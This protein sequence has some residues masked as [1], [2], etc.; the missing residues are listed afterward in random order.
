MLKPTDM[1]SLNSNKFDDASFQILFK[2]CFVPFCAYY[3]YKFGFSLD[4]AKEVVHTGF[5]KLWEN[6]ES[7]SPGLSAKAYLR[8]TIANTSLDL[9]KHEKVKQKHANYVFQTNTEDGIEADFDKI[10]IKQLS[11]D[12]SKAV[13]DLPD[14]MRLIFELSRNEGLKYAEIANRLDIS[15]KTVETQMSRALAKLRQK[16]AQYLVFLILALLL[17]I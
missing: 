12:I 10:D 5:I 1:P 17:K 7:I 8:K 11:A 16:L 9:L 6:R 13:S 15:V 2:E 14:Q 3:Q 4:I